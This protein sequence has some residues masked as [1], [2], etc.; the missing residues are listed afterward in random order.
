MWLSPLRLSAAGAG[1]IAVQLGQVPPDWWTELRT[2]GPGG[3]AF[4]MLLFGVMAPKYV[5]DRLI[6][7]L[8]Q[9]RAQ[10]DDLVAQQAE[11][12]PVLVEVKNTLLPTLTATQV[13][14]SAQSREIS[15]L[16]TEVREVRRL[17]DDGPSR[18]VGG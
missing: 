12:I 7:D 8:A 1:M 5:V 6:A 15:E 2:W 18:R 9:A 4:A 3:I 11:V 17:L 16:R 14:L 13:A 10:R